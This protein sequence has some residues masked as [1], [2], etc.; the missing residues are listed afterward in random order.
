MK[1]VA[2]RRPR[3]KVESNVASLLYRGRGGSVAEWTAE[4]TSLP[5]LHHLPVT[6]LQL[7][8]NYTIGNTLLVIHGSINTWYKEST[9]I[10]AICPSH[11]LSLMSHKLTTTSTDTNTKTSDIDSSVFIAVEVTNKLSAARSQLS[12]MN[13]KKQGEEKSA[14][15]WWYHLEASRIRTATHPTM[16]ACGIIGDIVLLHGGTS[17]P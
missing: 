17:R 15:S 6:I 12:D 3:T 8:A 7:I 4:L 16:A 1:K 9:A 11:P 5:C 2:I 14:S 13:D 10:Y